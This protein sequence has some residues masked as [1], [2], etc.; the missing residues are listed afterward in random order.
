MSEIPPDPNAPA[1][2]H[3]TSEDVRC[4]NHVCRQRYATSRRAFF[5]Q[6]C[7]C[8]RC[9]SSKAQLLEAPAPP[10]PGSE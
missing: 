10:P 5:A 1:G 7:C 2:E 8:P 4:M 9:G 6:G 3:D